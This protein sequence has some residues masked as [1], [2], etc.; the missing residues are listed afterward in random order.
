MTIATRHARHARRSGNSV[1]RRSTASPQRVMALT[2]IDQGASSVSNFA[3]AII[4]A[5]YSSASALGVFA[6]LTTTYVLSQGLV[7]SLSSDCLLTRSDDEQ[8]R[9]S[10]YER[11]GYLVAIVLSV[12]LAVLIV[13]ISGI[14]PSAF[15]LPFIIFAVSFPLMA[16]QDFARFIGISRYDPGYAIRLDVAWLVIFVVAFVVLRHAGLTTLPWLFG[17]WSGAGAVV[18]LWTLPAHL[19]GRGSGQLLRFWDESERGVGLRFAGQFMLVTS[20]TYLIAYLLLLVLSLSAIG[21][22]K[23]AQLA[24]GPITVLLAGVQSA[25]IALAAKRFQVDVHR[26]IQ[27]LLLVGLASAGMTLLWTALLYAAPVH[28]MT[29]IFG[30]VWPKAR[31]I[32]PFAGAGIALSGFSGSAISGLRAMR[33]AHENLRLALLMM[34]FLFVLCMGGAKLYGTRGAAGGLAAAGAIYSVLGWGL[35]IRVAR[36]FAPGTDAIVKDVVVEMS[37]P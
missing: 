2:V 6:I 36:G 10:M 5:H 26:A 15:T 16:C 17:A 12:S 9:R 35:L 37:E 27:L 3:L 8:G 11:A 4:V 31:V 20:W 21:E 14:L 34:P 29:T 32:I 24:L 7:R 28:T 23:L 1:S 22:F 19:T 30:P 25:L 13:A 18:G 33:A